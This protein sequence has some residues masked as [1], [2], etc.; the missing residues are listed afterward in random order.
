MSFDL[1]HNKCL[2]RRIHS[3]CVRFQSSTFTILPSLYATQKLM[4]LL[5]A[6]STTTRPVWWSMVD[7]LAWDCG[8]Q[9]DKKIT[10]ASDPYLT[11]KPT[12]SWSVFQLSA[13]HP[14]ITSKPRYAAPPLL[15]LSLANIKLQDRTRWDQLQIRLHDLLRPSPRHLLT[16]HAVV[17]RDWT[18]CPQCSH[19]LG[20]HQAWPPR[21]PRNHRSPTIPQNGAC[22]LWAG[23]GRGQGNQSTQVPGMF[24]PNTAEPE[25]RFRRSYPV[26]SPLPFH[27]AFSGLRIAICDFHDLHLHEWTTLTATSAVL[28]PRPAAKSGRKNKCMIL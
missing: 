20:W 27:A 9:P 17:P 4:N 18:S 7:R 14:L 23:L 25:E 1:L 6:A 12:F 2:S 10:T 21:R 26:P 15:C 24:R 16:P 3:Y 19:H 5:T 11:P 28:N 8:I 13:H 22:L